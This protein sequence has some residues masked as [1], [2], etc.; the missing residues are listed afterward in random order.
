MCFLSLFGILTTAK[1]IDSLNNNA[2]P[3]VVDPNRADIDKLYELRF[4][5]FANKRSVTTAKVARKKTGIDINTVYA[6]VM[7]GEVQIENELGI[8]ESEYD[9]EGEGEPESQEQDVDDWDLEE[10][11]PDGYENAYAGEIE[12]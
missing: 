3:S 4:Y 11:L 9:P 8:D 12:A 5:E 10:E 1:I 6:G 2:G 7:P